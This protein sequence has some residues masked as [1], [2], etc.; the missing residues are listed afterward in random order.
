MNAGSFF[1]PLPPPSSNPMPYALLA[2]VQMPQL[3][4][5]LEHQAS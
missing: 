3:R 4:I 5:A 1:L 2:N